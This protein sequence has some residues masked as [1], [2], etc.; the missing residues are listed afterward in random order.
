MSARFPLP[1]GVATMGVVNSTSCL[2]GIM[3]SGHF[4]SGKVGWHAN[5][6][7]TGLDG[8]C[9]GDLSKLKAC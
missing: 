5:S 7:E 2:E 8:C 4:A 6:V 3:L 9:S 1:E